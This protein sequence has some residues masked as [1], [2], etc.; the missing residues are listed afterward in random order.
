MAVVTSLVAP[1]VSITPAPR[2][3]AKTQSPSRPPRS[4]SL[5]PVTVERSTSAPNFGRLSAAPLPHGCRDRVEVGCTLIASVLR[6]RD[7]LPFF[8]IDVIRSGLVSGDKRWFG[9]FE[10]YSIFPGELF[11]LILVASSSLGDLFFSLCSRALTVIL[12]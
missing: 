6:G 10:L 9:Y 8:C 3:Q 11:F 4:A 5:R 7:S 1:R 2:V 12:F